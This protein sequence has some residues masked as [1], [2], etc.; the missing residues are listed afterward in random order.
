MSSS[1]AVCGL[2][3]RLRR[4]RVTR[5]VHGAMVA[6]AV[7]RKAMLAAIVAVLFVATPVD[8]HATPLRPQT[9]E[10]KQELEL[11]STDASA[12][13]S[14]LAEARRSP[15]AWRLRV[16]SIERIVRRGA[17]LAVTRAA[18]EALGAMGR[19]SSSAALRP[20]L[21][22]REVELHEAAARALILTGGPEAVDA[23]REGLRGPLAVVR[24][25]SATGL[26]ELGAASA[27]P[28]LLLALDKNVVEAA[29]AV[30]RLCAPAE[31]SRLIEKLGPMAPSVVVSGL[32]PVFFRAAPLSDDALVA[33]ID[34]LHALRAPH[35]ERY[36]ATVGERWT[37][38]MRVKLA[39]SAAAATDAGP[40][41]GS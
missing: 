14:T 31:C 15:K 35:V 7:A 41:G 24:A 27:L 25:L 20:Y 39:L 10:A 19:P 17:P 4:G 26:G 28:D 38:S 40:V 32:E 33:I 16:P 22:H 1:R 23:F 6:N 2:V 11:R 37:G 3:V 36:L 9:K 30:G 5:Y 29:A 34:Q 12:L 18:I 13:L 21:R 8:G